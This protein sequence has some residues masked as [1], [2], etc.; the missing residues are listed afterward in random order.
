MNVKWIKTAFA[1]SAVYDFI[2]AFAFL[3]LGSA[4]YDYFGI[5]RP[6][7]MGYL[8]LPALLIL[9]FAIMYWR[10]ASDPV[11][12]KVLIPYGIGLKVSYSSVVFYHWFHDSVPTLWIPFAWIDVA[13]LILFVLA[14]RKLG[15]A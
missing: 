11:K 3:F 6:N 5:E 4:I 9:V 10:I 2:L 13:F 7:H 12:F 1:A 15:S 8:H 14:W